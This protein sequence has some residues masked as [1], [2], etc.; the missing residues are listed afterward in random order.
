M[1]KVGCNKSGV[2]CPG[3]QTRIRR[4]LI[5][6]GAIGKR[7]HFYITTE[8]SKYLDNKKGAGVTTGTNRKRTS[9]H[10][11]M[12]SNVLIFY[13]KL[14]ILFKVNVDYSAGLL[15]FTVDHMAID[16]VSVHAGGMSYDAF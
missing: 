3:I 8:L 5:E 4:F 15:H 12:V 11:F 16:S 14:H 6:M 1:Q 7:A 2:A 13:H 9:E 10:P